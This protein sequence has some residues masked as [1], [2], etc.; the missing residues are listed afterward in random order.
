[1]T[2]L[3]DRNWVHMAAGALAMGGWAAFA[4]RGHPAPAPLLAGLVQG[5]LTAVITL[6]LKRMLEAM[7]ARLAGRAAL[8][9]PP[10]AACGLSAGLL[11]LVHAVAGTPEILRT[12]VVPVCVSTLY[13]TA[14]AWRL[15]SR[16]DG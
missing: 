2:A 9:L 5:G 12:I 4:N 15:W 6:G 10:L 14:Y 1:M 16:R 13:A 3:L 11:S 7:A 8:V